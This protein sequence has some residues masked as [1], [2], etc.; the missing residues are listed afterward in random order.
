M[1]LD[2]AQAV[3]EHVSRVESVPQNVLA[4]YLTG[5]VENETA[6]EMFVVF[7]ANPE[8]AEVTLPAGGWS[9]YINGEKA[10]TQA[11]EGVSGKVSVAPI[12]A[13]VLIQDDSVPVVEQPA[14]VEDGQDENA[15]TVSEPTEKESVNI[16]L[17]GVVC[18]VVLAVVGAVLIVLGKGKRNKK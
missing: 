11:L 9:V 16:V 8:A 1:R 13:M 6:E 17:I 10:G 7:N 5:G 12:S 15:P 14:S 18:A 2:D 4:F 3:Q